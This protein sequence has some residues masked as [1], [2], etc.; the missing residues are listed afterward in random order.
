M[1]K[2]LI[3]SCCIK[4]C[5]A[6]YEYIVQ[7]KIPSSIMKGN[8]IIKGKLYNN[9]TLDGLAEMPKM[10]GFEEFAIFPQVQHSSIPRLYWMDTC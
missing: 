9:V 3:S 6:M 8:N 7:G 10:F 1:S 5:T 2:A 4:I